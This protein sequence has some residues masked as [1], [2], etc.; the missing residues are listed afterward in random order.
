MLITADLGE[1][2]PSDGELRWLNCCHPRCWGWEF[3]VEVKT[4]S[5]G[6]RLGGQVNLKGGQTEEALVPAVSLVLE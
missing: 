4:P 5:F 3:R 6:M 1:C 2:E